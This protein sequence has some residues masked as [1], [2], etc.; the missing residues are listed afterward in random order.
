MQTERFETFIDAILAIMMTVM[1]LKIP[2]PETLTFTGIW[3]LKI[4]YL[5]YII[6]FIVLF[7][8]W[9][10]HRKF[11]EKVQNIDD[12]VIWMYSVLIFFTTFVPYLTAWVAHKPYDLVPEIM[13]GFIFFI[14]NILFVVSTA[15][16]IKKD[17]HNTLLEQISYNKIFIMNTTLFII[18]AIIATHGYPIIMM[19]ICLLTIITWNLLTHYQETYKTGEN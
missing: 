13:F 16:T 19:I 15:L 11:F 4:M 2:Q 17:T 10:H 1:V 6:S 7:S 14:V 9:D 5:A 12:H 18:G 3:D 8:I